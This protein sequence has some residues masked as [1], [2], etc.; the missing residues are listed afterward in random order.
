MNSCLI[1][2][3]CR[4]LKLIPSLAVGRSCVAACSRVLQHVQCITAPG[5]VENS[6]SLVRAP[7][8]AS[9]EALGPKRF[10]SI[11]LINKSNTHKID[12]WVVDTKPRVPQWVSSTSLGQHLLE[13]RDWLWS[14]AQ[15][16]NI[17][18]RLRK[19]CGLERIPSSISIATSEITF[20]R[21]LNLKKL[22]LFS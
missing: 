5:D 13:W 6:E 16:V 8:L 12:H 11:G 20:H 1:S 19:T 14:T 17:A 22:N 3:P 9:E 15:S 4:W 7:R 21:R 18:K 2:D 10:P